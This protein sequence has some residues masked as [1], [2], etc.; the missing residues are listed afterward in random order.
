VRAAAARLAA[1]I[2]LLLMMLCS[3][4]TRPPGCMG[5]KQRRR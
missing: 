5:H 2:G 4:K 3:W 1:F